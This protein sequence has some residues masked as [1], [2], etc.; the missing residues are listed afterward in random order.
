MGFQ[1]ENTWVTKFANF[2]EFFAHHAGLIDLGFRLWDAGV[3][4]GRAAF[5]L[6]W[7]EDSRSK[8]SA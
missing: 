3:A 7:I 5:D 2:T 1:R 4:G 8:I 6:D